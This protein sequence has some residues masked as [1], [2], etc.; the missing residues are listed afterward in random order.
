MLCSYSSGK[1]VLELDAC[2]T[3]VSIPVIHYPRNIN[4]CL[5]VFRVQ[6]QIQLEREDEAPAEPRRQCHLFVSPI[7]PAR[8][9]WN[10]ALPNT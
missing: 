5:L 10:L 9:G 8:L 3:K 7:L 1:P 4:N 2:F 6:S